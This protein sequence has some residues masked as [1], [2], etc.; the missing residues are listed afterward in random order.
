MSEVQTITMFCLVCNQGQSV[1]KDQTMSAKCP[2]CTAQLVRI[3]EKAESLTPEK[4]IGQ[5][6]GGCR[7]ITLLG[8]GNMGFVYKG[9]Q[10]GL[11]REVAIKTLPIIEKY[12][13]HL[14]R[15]AYEAK[16]IAKL[17][18]PNIVQ[19]YDIGSDKG[20]VFIVM[21]LLQGKTLS[22]EIK[23]GVMPLDQVLSI[24]T[25]AAKGIGHAH[26]RGIIHRDLKTEN[27]MLLT[28]GGVKVMDFGLASDPD[29]LD[30]MNDRIAGT[31]FYIAPEVWVRKDWDHK[32]DLYSL[33]VI[34]YYMLT[35]RRP[36]YA[37]TIHDLMYKHLKVHPISPTAINKSIPES[38]VAIVRKLISKEPEKRY[39]DAEELIE[40]IELFRRGEIPR[41]ENQHETIKIC[42][43][44]E[45]PNTASAK[46]C[47]VCNE[48]LTREK[49]TL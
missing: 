32:S 34:F 14:R 28:D 31:P 41:A 5:N 24:V 22:D 10:E 44:C 27:I 43:L 9:V 39:H 48:P 35:G 45:S 36:F 19:V 3:D 26:S 12:S 40:D 42:G 33:G 16:V 20:F 47:K 30:E 23:D 25:L 13:S 11:E 1:L 15:L 2:R 38:V 6:L 17:E 7:I 49:P 37:T 21:Q 4:L 18:H 8:R 46:R 29:L